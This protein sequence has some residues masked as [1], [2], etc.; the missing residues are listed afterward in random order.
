IP[1]QMIEA[2]AAY[3]AAN[4]LGRADWILSRAHSLGILGGAAALASNWA[5]GNPAARWLIEKF[6]GIARRR[7][8]AR[9]ARRPY[10][11]TLTKAMRTRPPQ[12]ARENTVVYYVGDYA[13]SYDPELAQA[14]TA[15][16]KRNGFRVHVPPGQWGSGM[17]MISAGDLDP[18]REVA[19]HNV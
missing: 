6:L 17:A 18:A 12:S 16:L 13:N 3:V 1:H 8:L 2:K 14:F 7:K 9:F 10:L 11:T 4:G 15:I 19:E 5:I